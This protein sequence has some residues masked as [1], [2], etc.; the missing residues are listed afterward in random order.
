M[1]RIVTIEREQE[2][3]RLLAETA[4]IIARLDLE[5]ID[6][7]LDAAADAGDRLLRSAEF[8]KLTRRVPVDSHVP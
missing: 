2:R 1:P 6:G 3:I 7:R 5:A 4:V 8:E